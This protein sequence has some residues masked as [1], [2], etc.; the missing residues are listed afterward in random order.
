MQLVNNAVTKQISRHLAAVLSVALA[1]YLLR[2]LDPYLDI[3]LIVLLFLLPVLASTYFWGLTPGILAGF[4]AFLAFNYYFLPPFR[5]FQVH[6]T[7]DL[8]TLIIFLIV[9]V[10]LSQLIGQAREGIR[11]AHQRE[12]E[13]T[14]MYE[15]ISALAGL[16]DRRSIAAELAAHTLDSFDFNQV[17]SVIY[18]S[19]DEP[20]ITVSLPDGAAAGLPAVS[21]LPMLTA[22]GQ[23]GELRLWHNGAQ[24]PVE[25]K[26]LLQAF[27]SQGAL[28]LERIRLTRVEN[29]SRVLEESDR[30]KSSLLNS[31]SHELRT[32]LAAIKASVSSLRSSTV[33]WN[34]ADRHDLLATIEEETDQLNL[35][36][37]NI[38]DMSRIESGALK[39]QKRWNAAAEIA[40]GVVSKMRNLLLS[41]RLVMDFPPGLPPVQ[42]DYVMI[43]Q[44]FTNL[45]S[46]SI[47][48]APPGTEIN[49]SGRSD[50]SGFLVKVANQGPPVPEEHLTRIFDK[51]YRV[52]EAERITGTGLGLSI[53]KG[54]IE[55]HGGSIWA[56]NEAGGFAFYF[57]L[58]LNFDAA[59]PDLPAEDVDG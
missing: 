32:P 10:I 53:C 14:R 5:T 12:Q 57:R 3:Q 18:A 29:K 19:K 49:I 1:T 2:L 26:R 36:V 30:L 48:Y 47:K 41:H 52:T 39:P 56:A 54:I 59:P 16:Q 9:A 11:L 33:D 58:P 23:E 15:L 35:L 7:Q 46:N 8:I 40:M 45:I 43:Q 4:S 22:R 31:V 51:F 21:S 27:T 13:A 34:T 25:E 50:G 37:G 17:E 6:Q 24:L 38:L 55:A 28:A 44:V 20:A 42:V